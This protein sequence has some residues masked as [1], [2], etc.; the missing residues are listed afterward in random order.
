MITRKLVNTCLIQTMWMSILPNEVDSIHSGNH[1]ELFHRSNFFYNLVIYSLIHSK[2]YPWNIFSRSQLL[3]PLKYIYSFPN[4]FN[5][6][7]LLR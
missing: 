1:H 2:N 7:V 4:F 5:E 3:I 6:T